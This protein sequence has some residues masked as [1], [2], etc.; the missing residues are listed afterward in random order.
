MSKENEN[1]EKNP[2]DGLGVEKFKNVEELAKAYNNLEKMV[3]GRKPTKEDDDSAL[4][5]KI[6]EFFSSIKDSESKLDGDLKNLSDASA[7]ALGLPSKVT[8]PI[9]AQ[10]A[11][12][13]SEK[14]LKGNKKSASEM[15]KD[16][17]IKEAVTAAIGTEEELNSFKERFEAGQVSKREVELLAKL[18]GNSVSKE[19]G[20]GIGQGGQGTPDG[21]AAARQA[22]LMRILGN[23]QHPMH[24]ETSP[25]H[26]DALRQVN[27]LKRSLGLI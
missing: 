18:G 27:A 9:V 7:K 26:A 19:P 8:D 5:N 12:N 22:E 6:G 11:G 17:K 10:V 24:D 4:V 25:L 2:L 3:S 13:L 1:S 15:L 23:R 16:E 20:A 21:S 14:I